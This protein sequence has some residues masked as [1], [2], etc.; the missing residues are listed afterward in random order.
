LNHT[1]GGAGGQSAEEVMAGNDTLTASHAD[2]SS[3]AME[4]ILDATP[5]VMK[6]A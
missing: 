2:L 4:T 3:A 6:K 5:E 1:A